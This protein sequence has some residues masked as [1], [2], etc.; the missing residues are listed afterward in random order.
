[1]V[2]YCHFQATRTHN[3][4]P[5]VLVRFLGYAKDHDVWVNRSDLLRPSKK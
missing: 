5:Q 3:G 2:K 4:V 1:M